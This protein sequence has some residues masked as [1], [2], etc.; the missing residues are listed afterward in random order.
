ME[1]STE[2]NE[3]VLRH[4]DMEAALP[5]QVEAPK[6]WGLTLPDPVPF[7]V[8]L[9]RWCP[10]DADALVA[11]HWWASLSAHIHVLLPRVANQE[12]VNY[13]LDKALR[14]S[15]TLLRSLYGNSVSAAISVSGLNSRASVPDVAS[16]DEPRELGY[17]TMAV[18]VVFGL[19]CVR[20]AAKGKTDPITAE[21]EEIKNLVFSAFQT[22]IADDQVYGMLVALCTGTLKGSVDEKLE[23]WRST[24]AT[25]TEGLPDGVPAVQEALE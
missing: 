18:Q 22:R 19:L 24:M 17:W 21:I 16:W 14:N 1:E 3:A 15:L 12:K 2:T 11:L 13:R 4:D 20:A 8:S 25:A 6:A 23:Q 7:E 9:P 10:V 5:H